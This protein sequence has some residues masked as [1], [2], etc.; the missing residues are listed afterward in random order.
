MTTDH[1]ALR[2]VGTVAAIIG[3]IVLSLGLVGI[4]VNL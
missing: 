3:I 2:H 1:F 4:F